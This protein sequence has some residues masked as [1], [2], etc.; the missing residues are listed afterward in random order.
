MIQASLKTYSDKELFDVICSN[1]NLEKIIDLQDDNEY[2]FQYNIYEDS[3]I[4]KIMLLTKQCTYILVENE[5]TEHAWKEIFSLH[6][7]HTSYCHSN[8]V[9]RVHFFDS[10]IINTLKQKSTNLSENYLGYITLRP[11]PD[12]NLMLSFVVPNWNVLK[13]DEIGYIMTYEQDVHILPYTIPIKTCAF[14]SQDSVVTTCAHADIIMFSAY[15]NSKYN[16]KM[17]HV[18]DIQNC[19]KYHPLPSKGLK[20]SEIL[21]IFRSNGIPV[22]YHLKKKIKRRCVARTHKF[23]ELVTYKA[24][25]NHSTNI[26]DAYIES[27]LPVIVFNSNHLILVIGHTDY[28][29]RYIVYDDSGAFLKQTYSVNSFIGTVSNK[30]LFPNKNDSTYMVCATHRRVYLTAEEYDGF[31]EEFIY[32]IKEL[33]ESQNIVY[34]RNIIVDNVVLKKH[35]L[36]ILNS[37]LFLDDKVKDDIK[38]IIFVDLPHY[39][40]YTEIELTNNSMIV[41]VGDATYPVNT[42]LN[43]FKLIFSVP[44][45][46]KLKLLTK[47]NNK[48]LKH[49]KQ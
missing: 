12:F 47:I 48:E 16:H 14:Y 29:K 2:E 17:I 33:V 34:K 19:T 38:K 27:G 37:G 44:S 9:M 15:T 22:D 36:D 23:H 13:Y 6:Y 39:M 3:I 49:D 30:D 10:G 21:E 46:Y 26:L 24:A 41:L 32:N 40:W 45:Q 28:P 11:V 7:A 43:I 5:Y 4:S 31:V 42:T 25:L 20:A 1:F 35:L 8:K 18:S